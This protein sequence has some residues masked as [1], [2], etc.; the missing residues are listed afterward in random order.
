MMAS[1]ILDLLPA[2]GIP[3]IIYHPVRHCPD[4]DNIG[5]TI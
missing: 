1:A 3:Y 2:Y 4:M 5:N